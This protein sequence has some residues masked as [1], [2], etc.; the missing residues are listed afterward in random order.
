MKQR[1]AIVTGA[2]GGMGAA[3]SARLRQAG[4]LVAGF[5]RRESPA[6]DRSYVLDIASTEAVLSAVDSVADDLGPVDALVSGAGYYLSQAFTEV[7]DDEARN[8]LRVH[9]GGFFANARAVLPGMLER[10]H[11]AIVALASELA[12]GG[13]SADSH[14]ASAKGALL[15]AMRSLAAELADTGITVNAVAPGPTDT[16]MLA[17]DSPW[18]DAEYLATLPTRSL[19]SPDDIAVCV[20]FLVNRAGF[21]TGE[22]LNPNSGAVI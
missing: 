2:A 14:Y 6:A 18:R 7:S 12:I 13:G 17:P 15:G 11:G 8:M 20:E 19:A 22:T 5:D 21:T 4:W 9:L 10:G 16:P 3:I 1:V